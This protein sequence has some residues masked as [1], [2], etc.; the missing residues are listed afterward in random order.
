MAPEQS[1]RPPPMALLSSSNHAGPP[2]R[3]TQWTSSSLA[4]QTPFLLSYYLSMPVMSI[5][6]T[7][8]QPSWAGRWRGRLPLPLPEVSCGVEGCSI[9][10]DTQG[11]GRSSYLAAWKLGAIMSGP[12]AGQKCGTAKQAVPERRGVGRGVT[13]LLIIHSPNPRPAHPRLPR[14]VW[15]HWPS[16]G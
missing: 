12:C 14:T 16:S 10:A 6:A 1:P 15:P 5:S 7:R 9:L 13:P 2:G 4:R 11:T 8:L 3:H